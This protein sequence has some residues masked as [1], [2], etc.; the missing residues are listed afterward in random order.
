MTRDEVEMQ[1]RI[2]GLFDLAWQYVDLTDDEEK[3][4]LLDIA[5]TELAQDFIS[6]LQPS[7]V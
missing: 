1:I 6:R 3:L 7:L 5:V 4:A 2:S